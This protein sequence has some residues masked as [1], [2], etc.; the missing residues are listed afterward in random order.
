MGADGLTDYAF[1]A[2]V[3]GGTLPEEDFIRLRGRASAYLASITLGKS[4]LAAL[5]ETVR[6]SVD[7][8]LCA[9]VD[10]MHKAENGGD[11]ASE[12]NDGISITYAA[13]AQQTEQQRLLDAASAHLA[14]TGLL[15]RGCCF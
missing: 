1:Y 4:E 3:Y 9:V 14:W 8:A 12:S 7:M 10:T 15:Y 11:V 6:K 2:S 5:P 13:K